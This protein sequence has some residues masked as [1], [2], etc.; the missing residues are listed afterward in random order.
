MHVTGDGDRATIDTTKFVKLP[1]EAAGEGRKP[2]FKM[3][4]R[5]GVKNLS[6]CLKIF[7]PF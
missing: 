5:Y 2:K 1:T 6:Y 3:T 7:L 4:A